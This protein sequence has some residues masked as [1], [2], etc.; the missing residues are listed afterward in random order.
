QSA[1][2][3]WPAMMP[4]MAPMRTGVGVFETQ[5]PAGDGAAVAA[6]ADPP[7]RTVSLAATRIRVARKPRRVNAVLIRVLRSWRSPGADSPGTAPDL[8]SNR[9]RIRGRFGTC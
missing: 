1:L 8:M 5:V 9:R 6:S 3:G 2:A 7:A 4:R